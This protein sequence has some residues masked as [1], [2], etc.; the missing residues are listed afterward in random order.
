LILSQ[1][2]QQA[3]QSPHCRLAAAATV[4][5]TETPQHSLY[6]RPLPQRQGSFLSDFATFGM[7][8]RYL[9]VDVRLVDTANRKILRTMSEIGGS[10]LVTYIPPDERWKQAA[11]PAGALPYVGGRRFAGL[12]GRGRVFRPAWTRKFDCW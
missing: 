7:P 6:F 5:R 10:N 4:I 8:I 2:S 12:V 11:V 3:V 9:C 1:P